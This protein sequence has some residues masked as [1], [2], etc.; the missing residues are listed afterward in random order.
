MERGCLGRRLRSPGEEETVL[1]AQV[2]VIELVILLIVGL[3]VLLIV[4]VFLHVV[5]AAILQPFQIWFTAFLTGVPVKL[6]QIIGMRFRKVDPRTVVRTLIMTKQAG[7]ELSCEELE[8]AYLQGAD[9][10]RIAMAL[11]RATREGRDFTF[12]ELVDADL[13]EEAG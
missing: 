6:S 1:L 9:L 4:G 11:I 10:H 13:A 8:R 7:I 3:V 2:S 5:F 12:Q